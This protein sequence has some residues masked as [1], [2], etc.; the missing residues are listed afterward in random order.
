MRWNSLKQAGD[1]AH[2]I[3]KD[4]QRIVRVMEK[5]ICTGTEYYVE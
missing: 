4:E 1:S 3:H 5:D 2:I